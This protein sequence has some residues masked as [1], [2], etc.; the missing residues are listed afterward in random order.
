[1]NLYTEILL[2]FL[3]YGLEV[4]SRKDAGLILAG[5]R[6]TQSGREIDRLLEKL[7]H[8]RLLEKH[9]RGKKAEFRI[10][11]DGRQRMAVRDP[12]GDWDRQWDGKWRVLV[13]DVPE[14]RHGDR[15]NLWRALRAHK[16][17]L[18]QRS[19]WIWPHDL[20]G[21]L[22][23][24]LDTKGI[25][26]HFCGFEATRVFLCETKEIVAYAWNFL[27]IEEQ[28]QAYLKHQVARPSE[29]KQASDLADL[30]RVARV[31][32]RAYQEAFVFDPLLPR[33][34]WPKHYL[35]ERVA[36]RHRDFHTQLHRRLRALA[37]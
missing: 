27:Q 14:Q 10:T 15:V 36:R 20:T 18:I 7:R 6:Q 1:M 23:E 21:I 32:R 26:D 11:D 28:H 13:Y 2:G 12:A 17:G 19:V 4:M 5:Y 31:E 22:D 16:L 29:V 33:E 37:S 9:G 8:Q 3:C 30:A 34:L 35:G 24:I 25:P